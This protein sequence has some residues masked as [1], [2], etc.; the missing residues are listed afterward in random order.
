MKKFI[1]FLSLYPLKLTI[2]LILDL[3]NGPYC[4]N[5]SQAFKSILIF[6]HVTINFIT[7]LTPCSRKTKRKT[8]RSYLS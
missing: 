6:I 1:G 5:N 4:C 8:Q 3:S 7:L 2:T